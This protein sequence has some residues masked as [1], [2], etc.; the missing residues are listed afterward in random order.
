AC[1]GLFGLASFTAE[2]RTKEIGIR[3]ILGASVSQI[4]VLLSRE[5]TKWIVV[6]NIIA[7]PI[8]YYVMTQWLQNFA[9]KI[10]L[11]FFTFLVAGA[12]ALF[13]GLISVSFQTIRAA[14][15]NP[16][17]SLRYE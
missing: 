6:A 4:A 9:Y 13:I 15:A 7:W 5:F 14:T 8:A 1:L 16:V 10:N 11:D 3:K 17:D 2:Q 12:L